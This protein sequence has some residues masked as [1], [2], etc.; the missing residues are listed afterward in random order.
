[1]FSMPPS[2]NLNLARLLQ[3]TCCQGKV[4]GDHPSLVSTRLYIEIQGLDEDLHVTTETQHQMQGAR[5]QDVDVVELL[6]R[7]GQALMMT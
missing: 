1:M 3:L 4:R 5:L 2:L 7:E 6:D